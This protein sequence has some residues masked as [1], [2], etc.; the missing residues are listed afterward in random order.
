[1]Q[2]DQFEF[3]RFQ[4]ES[5]TTSLEL[6]RRLEAAAKKKISLVDLAAFIFAEKSETSCAVDSAVRITL[7]A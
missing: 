5:K 7:R 3:R 6:Q 2:P 4:S 1:M